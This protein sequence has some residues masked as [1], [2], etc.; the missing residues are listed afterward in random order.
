MAD[1]DEIVDQFNTLVDSI[2]QDPAQLLER[3]EVDRFKDI[4]MHSLTRTGAQRGFAKG[5][6][7]E[8]FIS[9]RLELVDRQRTISAK[10]RTGLSEEAGATAHA[11]GGSKPVLR[12]YRKCHS[13]EGG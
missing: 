7:E 10:L 2:R 4:A 9:K 12:L 13:R 5:L 1:F 8:F 3:G 11:V 6:D